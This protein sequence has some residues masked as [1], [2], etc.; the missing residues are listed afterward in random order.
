MQWALEKQD[1][2]PY[3]L[4]VKGVQDLA[5]GD[6]SDDFRVYAAQAAGAFLRYYIHT[7]A[8]M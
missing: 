8:V 2:R 4:A 7:F 1:R 5:D 6:K 3:F